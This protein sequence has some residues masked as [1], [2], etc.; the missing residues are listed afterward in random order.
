MQSFEWNIP[1]SPIQGCR[2]LVSRWA[3]VGVIILAAALPLV[4]ATGAE[5]IPDDAPR[6]APA[7]G[8]TAAAQR[9][10]EL[11]ALINVGDREKLLAYIKSTFTPGMMVPTPESIG[12]FLLGQYTKLGGLTPRRTLQSSDQQVTVLV[13]AVRQPEKWLRFVVGVEPSSPHRVQGVFLFPASAAMAETSADP[14]TESDLTGRLEAMVDRMAADDSFSGVVLLARNGRPVVRKAYGEADKSAHRPNRPETR[15]SFASLGKMFTAVAVAQLAEQGK[16]RYTDRIGQYLPD[17][18]SPQAVESV[19]VEQLLMHTSGLGDYLGEVLD[20]PQESNYESLA[21][22]RPIAARDVPAFSP[23]SKFRYSNIGYL[24]L[25]ALVEKLSGQSYFDYV[26]D[27]IFGP[28]G[29]TGTG[30][31][32]KT[33]PMDDRAVGYDRAEDPAGGGSWKDTAA[34]MVGRGTSAGGGFTTADDLLAFAVAL[35][36]GKLLRPE[37][38]NQLLDPRVNMEGTGK[39]YGYGFTI[40]RRKS[41]AK[42]YGHEGGFP[43][44]GALLEVDPESGY[45]LV[46]LSN[47]TAAATP[48]ADAWRDLLSRVSSQ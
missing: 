33:A 47:Y 22:Y 23:G 14:V 15:F 31:P 46:V 45:T 43:G 36:S 20:Y 27:H 48:V 21:D 28:A 29:M 10:D 17:W 40:M 18:L 9:F 39:R 30:F 12:D 2:T 3:R 8:K 42:V 6:T 13:Q 41:G 37:S 5:T 11:I 44:V 19:T 16:V 26:H 35:Q 7:D 32:L 25:G 4:P 1:R 38:V 34:L 24:L